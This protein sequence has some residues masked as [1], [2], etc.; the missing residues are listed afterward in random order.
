MAKNKHTE[1]HRQFTWRFLALGAKDVKVIHITAATEH[2][3]REMMPC[4]MVAIFMAQ[5][6]NAGESV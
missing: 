6:P 5:L 1:N 3:A 2:A 4:G